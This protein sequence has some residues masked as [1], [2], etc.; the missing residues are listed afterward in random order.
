MGAPVARRLGGDLRRRNDPQRAA[1]SCRMDPGGP[2]TPTPA[3]RIARPPVNR[4]APA[5]EPATGIDRDQGLADA[6]PR[7]RV[8]HPNRDASHLPHHHLR[9]AFC[10]FPQRGAEP[11]RMIGAG[12]GWTNTILDP[13]DLFAHLAA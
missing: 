8:A 9:V 12:S 3:A 1:L 13:A 10:L 4:R 6:N 2:T 7:P 11:R 5:A